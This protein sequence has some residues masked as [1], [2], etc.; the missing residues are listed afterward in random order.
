MSGTPMLTLQQAHALVQAR[1]PR[2]RLVGEPGTPLLRVHTDTRT[3]Q[4]GDLF[5]A[6]RG[7][8]FD[9]NDF[10]AQARAGG[11]AAA[12]AHPGRLAAGLPGIEVPDTLAA[13]GAL[14]AGWRARLDLPLVG[15]TGSNGKTTVT[16][17][18]ASVL[19]AWK[20]DA[21]FATQGNFNNDIGVPLM[22]LRLR[23]AHEAAVIELGMNHPGEIAVLAGIARP[24]VALVNN[25]QRE[26]LEFMHTVQA[27]AEENGSV[28]SALP[29]DG[30]AV[31]P[32]ADT[33]APLWRGLA[34]TRRC[35]TFCDRAGVAADVRC[36]DA[37]W[38]TGAWNVQID[39]PQG[40]FDGTLRIAGRHNVANALAATACALAAGAPLDAI[41]RGLAAFEPVKGRSRAFVATVAQPGG[42]PRR[43]TAVDDTYNANPDSMRAAIDV[44]AELP[45]PQ[46]LVMGDMGEVGDQGPQFHAEAGGHARERGIGRLFALGALGIHAVQAFGPQARHFDDMAS[47]LA[48]VRKA[49]PESGS[50]LV[51]GSR[52][53][54]M[55]QVVQ[56]LEAPDVL[57]QERHRPDGP[58]VPGA[59]RAAI[60][61]RDTAC[62]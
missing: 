16:Q 20:G 12:L 27:V 32:A 45:G 35:L 19:R 44:L 1:I 62:S 56:A 54:K 36:T 6:L 55:E 10:L 43:I 28:I 38:E 60:A 15:V 49:A 14:A 40:A 13:L 23:D 51:K 50:V 48:A 29:P 57:A 61:G 26:H 8:R 22:L 11:A 33:Y 31:F 46:L 9:A 34:G 24:T 41:A 3:L 4:A 5:V 58:G 59:A 21:A 2:A 30:V 37:R 53:M 42:A 17:M 18:I 47:L 52:F 7:E 25:A 39:T